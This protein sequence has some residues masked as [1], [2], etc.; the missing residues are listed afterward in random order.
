MFTLKNITTNTFYQMLGKLVTM[1]ITLLAT[2]V[3]TRNYGILGYGE[4]NLM[5]SYPALFF[6]IADFGLNAIGAREIMADEKNKASI[7]GNILYLRLIIAGLLFGL[8]VFSLIFMPYSSFLKVGIVLGL[9]TIITK[10]IFAT[11]NIIF[12]VKLRYDL[13]NGAF[14]LGY[15]VFL[16]VI[17]VSFFYPISLLFFVLC[18]MVGDLVAI[19]LGFHFIKR[20]GV[21]FDFKFNKRLVRSFMLTSLPLGLMF[22]FSQINFKADSILLSVL[23]LP[24]FSSYSNIEAVGIYGL[25]YKVFEVALV[26]PTFIMN[27]M[28][29]I[30]LKN[31]NYGISRLMGVF[32]K[33]FLTLFVMGVVIGGFGIA[34]SDLIILIL[35]GSKFT[36]SSNVL[37]I[38]LGSIVVFYLTQPLAWLIVTLKGE[39]YLPYIYLLAALFNVTLNLIFIPKYSFL[40]SSNITW[41]SEVLILILLSFTARKLVLKQR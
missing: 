18:Y 25:S 22:V 28:Y 2:Y 35:G 40:A 10:A 37:K 23:R 11:L 9:L 16:I 1:S 13:A 36:D 27:S 39:R 26:V 5:L 14:I 20:L 31:Y 19:S 34:F 15:V 21:V 24:S 7:L 38:L 3:I 6:I 12:Q 17:L 33:T 4:F 30:M 29:P 32:K 41:L 8:G